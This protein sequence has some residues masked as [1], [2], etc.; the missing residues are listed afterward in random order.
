[1]PTL[2]NRTSYFETEEGVEVKESLLLMAKDKKYNTES[3]YS[4][5]GVVYSDNLI[6]FVDKHMKYLISHPALDP[7]HYISNLR[8][9]TRLR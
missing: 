7:K 8:L 6:P 4:A 9:V 1:M 2:K 3:T 5:D